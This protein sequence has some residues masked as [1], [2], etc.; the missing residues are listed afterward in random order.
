LNYVIITFLSV[1]VYGERLADV[2][3]LYVQGARAYM[4]TNW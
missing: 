2:H 3:I 4:L 1:V